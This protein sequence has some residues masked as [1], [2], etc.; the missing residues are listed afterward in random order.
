MDIGIPEEE[1]IFKGYLKIEEIA[2][3]GMLQFYNARQAVKLL[4]RYSLFKGLPVIRCLDKYAGFE[5]VIR[6]ISR[7]K[8][9]LMNAL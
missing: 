4:S 1:R 7:L 5:L 3:S 9:F 8:I 2:T 6:H